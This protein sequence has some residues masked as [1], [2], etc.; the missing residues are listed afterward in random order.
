MIRLKYQVLRV[1]K[2]VMSSPLAPA[3]MVAE[4]II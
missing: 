2:P 1:L 4:R 3:P